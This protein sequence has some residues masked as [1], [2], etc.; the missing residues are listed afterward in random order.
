MRS[1]SARPRAA[2][3]SAHG[4]SRFDRGNRAV[5]FDEM[6]R[7]RTDLADRPLLPEP[8]AATALLEC[9][10]ALTL[11][12]G[13]GGPRVRLARR[14]GRPVRRG[15]ADR[16]RGPDRSGSTGGR[17]RTAGSGSRRRPT[18]AAAVDG[19]RGMARGRGV[20]SLAR[21]ADGSPEGGHPSAGSR[22]PAGPH[23]AVRPRRSGCSCSVADVDRRAGRCARADRPRA[24]RLTA[25]PAGDDATTQRARA[26]GADP[27]SVSAVPRGD[28]RGSVDLGQHSEA[29][30]PCVT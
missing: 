16:S 18:P 2:L 19:R 12:R 1:A 28:R 29:A 26:G 27:P 10:A 8:A 23:T 14:P 11:G 4:C 20:R 3:R 7:A 30:P 6:V 25:A 21:P 24:R 5:G 22:R 15:G 13:S 17:P 9:R